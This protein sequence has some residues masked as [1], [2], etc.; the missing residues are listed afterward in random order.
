[1]VLLVAATLLAACSG[2]DDGAAPGSTTTTT[3]RPAGPTAD[4]STELRG[5]D[6]AFVAAPEPDDLTGWT[7]R[8][9]LATGSATSY[10]E[11]ER[12]T[13]G[14]WTFTPADTV[15]YRTRVL[16]RTPKKAF[17]GTVVVEWLNVSGG[18]DAEPEWS[19]LQEE[20]LRSG[21]AWV[22]VSAQGIGVE[23]GPTAV[24]VEGVPG[25]DQAGKGLKGID[26]ARYGELDHPGDGFS[27][28]IYTQVARAVR[29]GTGLDGLRPTHVLAAGESQSAF[30]LT[31]YY[32]GV[33]PLTEAF[34]GFF[35]HSRGG[36][37]L[38]LPEPGAFADI[39][40]ALSG[41]PAVFRTDLDAPVMDIQAESDVTGVLASAKAR[42]D[43][44]D[45]FRLWEVAGTAHADKHLLG[46][47]AQYVDC[48]VPINDG[49]LHVVAK[50]AFHALKAW[51]RDGTPPAEQPRLDLGP[52][53]KV[54]RDADGIAA[55]GARTPPVDV[56]VEVLSGEPGPTASTICILLGSTRPLAPGRYAS[57][58]A[59]Q[60]QY[61][62]A[63][64]E[65]IAAGLVLD[66]DRAAIEAYAHPELVGG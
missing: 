54:Q 21:D 36:P 7:Q 15:D 35:V 29:A 32:D 23:G 13:D 6:G 60:E 16:V 3:A 40:G 52:D 37:G 10:T 8:E 62:A 59:Y 63:V 30:A 51:V 45:R 17:S 47:T 53:G 61:D 34:D 14:R 41:T 64:E 9:Y 5:G 58:S 38:A 20:L 11:G 39:A 56:P 31:T 2:S 46:P 55:G 43:D 28:D 27:F 57:R 48:G 4:L 19:S 66:A 18:V 25:A 22:G 12:T 42:Q 50:A 49:P 1:V 24:K 65:A 33:Q 26:P 44:S